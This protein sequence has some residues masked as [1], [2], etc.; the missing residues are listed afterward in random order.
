MK[1]GGL[2]DTVNNTDNLAFD[3]LQAFSIPGEPSIGILVLDRDRNVLWCNDAVQEIIGI[4]PD[5]AVGMNAVQIID[6]YLLP[7]LQDPSCAHCLRNLLHAETAPPP[8]GCLIRTD[9]GETCLLSCSCQYIATGPF[10]DMIVIRFRDIC[11]PERLAGAYAQQSHLTLLA[12]MSQLFETAGL[13]PGE[14]F[15]AIAGLLPLALHYPDQAYARVVIDDTVY[16]PGR[17]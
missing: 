4:P 3:P 14:I 7:R 6:T 9:S 2:A 13:S 1:Y 8:C 15:T 17:S 10:Q 12:E 16:R 5:A 11:R